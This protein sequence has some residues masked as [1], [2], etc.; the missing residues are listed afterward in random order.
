MRFELPWQLLQSPLALALV[1]I[2]AV[3]EALRIAI[4]AV[5]QLA[6]EMLP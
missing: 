1:G 5:A 2:T 3:P 6:P 4:C